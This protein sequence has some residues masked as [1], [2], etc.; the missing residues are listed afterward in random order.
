MSNALVGGSSH[1]YGFA[2]GEI[3]EQ[4]EVL[5]QRP[6]ESAIQPDDSI[7]GHGDNDMYL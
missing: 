3:P 4:A 7:L 5:R 6:R 1:Q 2:E